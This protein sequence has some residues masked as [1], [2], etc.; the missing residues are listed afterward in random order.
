[1]HKRR[2]GRLP[3]QQVEDVDAATLGEVGDDDDVVTQGHRRWRQ[4]LGLDAL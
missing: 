3:G 4:E 2:G 1:V